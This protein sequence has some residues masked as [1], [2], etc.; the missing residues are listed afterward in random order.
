MAY[1]SA[2][3]SET[4]R[5]REPACRASTYVDVRSY[6]ENCGVS[7]RQIDH[8]PATAATAN[9]GEQLALLTVP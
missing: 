3:A 4:V 5:T 9:N 6:V 8:S 2:L 7:P 1:S